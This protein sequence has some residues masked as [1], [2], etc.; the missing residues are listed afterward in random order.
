MNNWNQVWPQNTN[1]EPQ[2]SKTLSPQKKTF[3]LVVLYYKKAL[4]IFLTSSINIC[5]NLFYLFSYQY[6]QNTLNFAFWPAKPKIFT[7]WLFTGS[8]PSSVLY[9]KHKQFLS[10]MYSYHYLAFGIMP[11]CICPI[12]IKPCIASAV[13]LFAISIKRSDINLIA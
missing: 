6:L 3:L 12:K 8:L 7:T 2:P 1:F 9:H 10:W 13:V 4:I 11:F 5:W